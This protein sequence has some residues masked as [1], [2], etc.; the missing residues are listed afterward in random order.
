MYDATEELA[1]SGAAAAADT[2]VPVASLSS[3]TDGS[4]AAANPR[5]LWLRRCA[6]VIMQP[7]LD[8]DNGF[9]LRRVFFD[10]RPAEVRPPQQHISGPHPLS[11]RDR[12]SDVRLSLCGGSAP[13][14]CR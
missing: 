6:P 3:A 9:G 1:R 11:E 10:F 5:A 13:A 2:A 12:A 7:Q 14:S 8:I 4:A